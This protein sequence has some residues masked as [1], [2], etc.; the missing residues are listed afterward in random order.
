MQYSDDMKA[1]PIETKKP[2]RKKRTTPTRSS[3]LGATDAPLQFNFKLCKSEDGWAL[4]L[5]DSK[6]NPC[7]PDYRQYTSSVRDALREFNHQVQ[8]EQKYLR[9]DLGDQ[10]R[11]G[12]TV[13]D[14]SGRL[15]ELALR[16]HLLLDEEGTPLHPQNQES[17]ITLSIEKTSDRTVAVAPLI[18][19]FDQI[20]A[21]RERLDREKTYPISSELV[22]EGQ[23]VFHVSDLGSYWT[24]WFLLTTTVPLDELHTY[25]AL[26]LSKFPTISLS[27]EGY[28][29][30]TVAPRTASSSLLFK[31][32]DAYGFLHI[33]PLIHLDAYPPGFFED[34]DITKIVEIDQDEKTLAV[35]EVVYPRAP[36][37]EFR[38]LLSLMGKEVKH[39]VF[40]EERYF[41]L[42][43]DFAQRF[44]ALHMQDLLARF[45]LFQ[46]SVLGKYKVKFVK[47]KMRLSLGDGIDYFEGKADIDVEGQT[48]SFNRFLSEYRKSGYILLND[49]SKAYPDLRSINRFERLVHHASKQDETV[50]VS[51]FDIPSLQRDASL[52]FAGDGGLRAETFY[53]GF[54]TIGES[55]GSYAIEGGE[56]RPYQVYGVQWMEYLR[57][58]QMGACLADEM[59][60]GKTVEVIA[61]LRSTYAAGCK[62]PTLILVPRTLIYNWKN[63]LQ[64]F[65][66]ELQ[67]LLHYGAARDSSLIEK[68]TANIVI[69]S[70]ATIRNDIKAFSKKSFA[71]VILDESQNIK[72]LET[73]TTNAVLALKARYR[74]ALS[75]TPVENN[76]GDLYSLFRFLNPSFFGSQG[77]F[78]RDYIRPIQ[79]H[80]DK[81]VLKDLKTRVY[82]F[83]L[84]RVKK[85][86]LKD[87][88]P[89]T[90]QVSYVELDEKHLAIYNRRRE[91]LKAKVTMAVGLG[92]VAKNTFMILQAL[93]EL[94]RLASVPEA[95]GEF[96]EVSAKRK[97]LK[98]VVASITSDGH[99]CLIFTNF[100]ATIE[101]I[102]E[103]LEEMGI[104]YLS[105]T[106]ATRDRQSLVQR[107]QNDPSI[108]AFIM[109]LKTGGVGLNLTAADYVFIVDP[110]WNRAAENQAIDRTHRI[111]QENPVFCYRMIAKDTIEEKI[112]E[113]QQRKADLVASL[114]TSDSNAVKSLSEKDI[115]MLLG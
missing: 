28:S 38:D 2:T 13:H 8:K 18:L 115:E 81:D 30:H 92:G 63:E 12:S 9:W 86:V 77:E 44:L 103:D 39:A 64:R 90:E 41:I 87:L 98:E 42:E 85:N 29:V 70:Y 25:L 54:N 107:F 78:L 55:Q 15:M 23:R 69:S 66:P 46:S 16:S 113:L 76:L 102:G 79:D 108:G 112:L 26:A 114:L 20:L 94:R 45:V 105:M 17:K 61:L 95:D 32:I 88:P 110:W 89:K 52:S 51:F 72:N 97:Y 49:G 82:P 56:L 36:D 11:D 71:Y 83:M 60:L 100:L 65:A 106:G 101:L 6:G 24:H 35:G 109:T 7:Q 19:S 73:Q 62:E 53:K 43:P 27:F 10:G 4:T 21:D 75:G 31:E 33:L 5:C 111:G 99:K 84:R 37:N 34:Q 47:P 68:S 14:P 58:H 93:T 80:H 48:F 1:N 104:G 3:P 22:V 40:E 59:G 74:L 96:Y 67:C 50:R 57:D 91:E